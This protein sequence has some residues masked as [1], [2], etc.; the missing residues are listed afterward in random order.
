M[1]SP[2]GDASTE[3][4][5]RAEIALLWPHRNGTARERARVVECRQRYGILSSDYQAVADSLSLRLALRRRSLVS[6]V[7][8]LRWMTQ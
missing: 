2:S 4:A 5:L 7:K 3:A 6:L 8:R 1:T